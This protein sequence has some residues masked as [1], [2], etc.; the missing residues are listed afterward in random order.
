MDFIPAS[1]FKPQTFA[2]KPWVKPDTV[3]IEPLN[4]LTNEGKK[5]L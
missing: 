3:S 5:A 4:T 2:Y 1:E